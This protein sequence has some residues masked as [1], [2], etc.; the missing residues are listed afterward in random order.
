[1]TT[2]TGPGG[3]LVRDPFPGNIIPA[4][5]LDPIGVAL[6]NLFPLPNI[7]GRVAGNYLSNPVKRFNQDAF[8]VRVD[9]NFSAADSLFVRFSFDHATQFFP[10]GLPG[11]GSGPS[12]AFSS[13]N[14]R[15]DA[16][17]V[18]ISETHTLSPVS[19]N[20][21]TAGFNRVFNRMRSIGQGTNF[22][23]QLG[24]PGANLGDDIT[25]GV[26]NIGLSGGFNRIGDRLFT[27]FVGGTNVYQ[28]GDTFSHIRGQHTVKFGFNVR[29]MQM[30]TLGAA[31]PDGHFNFD[32][33]VTAGFNPAGTLNSAT[34]HSVASLLLGLPASGTR[35]NQYDGWMIGRRW[36][37]YRWFLQD[38]WK[39]SSSLTLNLGLAYDITTPQ[40]EAHNRIANFDPVSRQWLIAG[41]NTDE[42][43]GVRTDWNNVQ[44]RIGLAWSPGGSTKT[45]VRAGYGIFFDVSAN[46]GVQGLYQ[47]PPFAADYSFTA[48]N[49]TPVRTLATGF[50]DVPRPDPSTYTGNVV[51]FQRDFTQGKIQQWN[52][53]LQHELA[54]GVVL[55][56]AYA[57]TRGSQI[58]GKGYN[59]N[60]APPGP[61]FNTP[62]R[63]PFPQY[64][65]FN[66]ILSRGLLR[67][68][69]FQVRA[70]KRLSHGLYVLSSYTW[71][72][73][74]TNGLSQNVGV[75]TGVKYFPVAPAILDKGLSDTDVRHSFTVSYLY[76]LPFGRGRAWASGAEGLL[77]AIIGNWQLSGITRAR[78]G[79]ALPISVASNQSGTALGNRP[80]V[81]CNP[82]LPKDRQ[83]VTRF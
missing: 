60:T 19:I 22:A 26:I 17:N 9:H 62:A 57:G 21:F 72:K 27:P 63:R 65:N 82:N 16:R 81:R 56:L 47:N 78:S 13:T 11:F 55:T 83:S 40:T 2:R 74:F 1:A 53:N 34:G 23:R 14:F 15:T 79:F 37:E 39:V 80:D 24:I 8:N 32:N 50:P 44:P 52:L 35:S 58:Q 33:F 48:N 12:A 41:R 75:N 66:A 54:A 67:Y 46:G 7:P 76:D 77:Q 36:K 20:Q 42:A 73:A 28:A 49:I 4:N 61:G 18:A 38:D 10:N 3:V 31:W 6:V 5:R 70:E 68:D 59:T 69:S 51:L 25:S 45:V 30:N 71:S 29:A 43:A 64:N